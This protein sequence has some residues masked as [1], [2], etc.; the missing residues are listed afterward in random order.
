LT[1][2]TRS[3][4]SLGLS[5]D[6]RIAIT[7]GSENSAR[8]WAIRQGVEVAV[9]PKPPTDDVA[10]ETPENTPGDEPDSNNPNNKT[11][12]DEAG[13]RVSL[14]ELFGE[15]KLAGDPVPEAAERQQAIKLI[16]E[17]FQDD[18]K[19]AKKPPEKLALAEKLVEQAG[20][21]Q[22]S[23]ER[24]ALLSEAR[25]RAREAGNSTLI[26][27]IY[28]K[29]AG[30]F[31][32]DPLDE[33]V[34]TFDQM[35]KEAGP[36]ATKKELAE[37]LLPLSDRALS[38]QKYATAHRLLSIAQSAAAKTAD[39]QLPKQIAARD[40]EVGELRKRF[41]A[42]KA[43]HDTLAKTPDDAAAS[44][45]LGKYL[46]FDKEDWFDGL[47]LLA[48]GSDEAL[49]KLAAQDAAHP[50]GFEEQV[51]LA[52]AWNAAAE[53]G[54]AKEKPKVLMRAEKWYQTALPNLPAGLTKA[55]VEKRLEELA[56]LLPRSSVKDKQPGETV[57]SERPATPATSGTTNASLAKSL[58]ARLKQASKKNALVFSQ[59]AGGTTG[60][61]YQEVPSAGML[62]VGFNYTLNEYDYISSLQPI[63]QS[64]KGAVAG[65][66]YGYVNGPP[67]TIM[68]K[69]GY[70]VS[71]VQVQ[72]SYFMYGLQVDFMKVEKSGLDTKDSYS[73]EWV[74]RK[75]SSNR[76]LTL[77]G[78]GNFVVGA[79]GKTTSQQVASLGVIQLPP[80]KA[81]K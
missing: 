25:D 37:N 63:Y 47:P 67:Q 35:Q 32:I 10:G 3:I 40:V 13:P 48:K 12:A 55:K 44:L 11:P 56:S 21:S 34:K 75:Y 19:A 50:S 80:E 27:D 73:S 49:A 66:M 62:L 78:D 42:A 39:K 79:Y 72:A 41:E 71:G 68:A 81:D 30:Q 74:G 58:A 52:D 45:A 77:G 60:N 59:L 15:P 7:S 33:M 69:K 23:T 46:C 9:K 16:K 64:S 4:T 18:Y 6:S 24:Y 51:K 57:G 1:G 20:N 76:Q 17:I 70:A 38:A 5:A 65:T 8:L 54:D 53:S 26:I 43:A 31:A 36:P 29:L 2:A 61:P 28:E 22:N 14:A